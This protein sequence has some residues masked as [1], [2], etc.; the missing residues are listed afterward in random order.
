MKHV[1]KVDQHLRMLFND[2]MVSISFQAE[3][4]SHR[5][6]VSDRFKLSLPSY[7]S[8]RVVARVRREKESASWQP[9]ASYKK[10]GLRY[11]EVTQVDV[12]LVLGLVRGGRGIRAE[13]VLW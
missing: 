11:F 6:A 7:V 2:L 3:T 8:S 1:S 10:D 5:K 13:V 4:H 12:L 9:C